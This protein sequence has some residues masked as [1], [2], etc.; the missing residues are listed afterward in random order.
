MSSESNPIDL[1]FLSGYVV[2]TGNQT[3]WSLGTTGE[4]QATANSI[5]YFDFD[6]PIGVQSVTV[7]LQ[8]GGAQGN[9]ELEGTI[10][11]IQNLN[12]SPSRP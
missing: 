6:Y 11:P 9:E 1:G 2:G 3:H 7:T 8:I 12:G 5:D 10:S 4:F